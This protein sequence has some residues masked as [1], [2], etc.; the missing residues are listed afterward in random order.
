ML[1]DPIR[2]QVS[3]ETLNPS[4]YYDED[5]ADSYQQP[6]A[7]RG[8]FVEPSGYSEELDPSLMSTEEAYETLDY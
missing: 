2:S 4:E 8:K 7:A 6:Q 5:S 3:R 1:L